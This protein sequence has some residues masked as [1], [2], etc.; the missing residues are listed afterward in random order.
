MP[1]TGTRACCLIDSDFSIASRV[2]RYSSFLPTDLYRRSVRL[3]ADAGFAMGGFHMLRR[4]GVSLHAARG[5]HLRVVMEQFGQS[6]RSLTTSDLYS[7]VAPA[8]LGDAADALER[9]L[10][11]T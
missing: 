7:H 4:S 6:Q 2:S 10:G 3:K 9:T 5:I 8:M 11:G 1:Q